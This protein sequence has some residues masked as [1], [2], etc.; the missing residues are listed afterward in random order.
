MNDNTVSTVEKRFLLGDLNP[1]FFHHVDSGLRAL[2]RWVKARV[3][4]FLSSNVLLISA[5]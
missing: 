3:S 5:R 4:E 1:T 2:T